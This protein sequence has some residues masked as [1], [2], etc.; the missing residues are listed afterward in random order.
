MGNK[1]RPVAPGPAPKDVL[2]ARLGRRSSGAA[3][4]HADQNARHVGAA[5]HTNRV[6]SRSARRAAAIRD[7][8]DD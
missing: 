6:G 3:G 4:I 1:N 2:A 5:G 7:S 8:R